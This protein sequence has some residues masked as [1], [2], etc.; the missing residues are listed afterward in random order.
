M[1]LFRKLRTSFG[2]TGAIKPSASMSSITVMK[3]KTT[4][5]GRDFI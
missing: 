4:A 1:S 5:A 2:N 3:I